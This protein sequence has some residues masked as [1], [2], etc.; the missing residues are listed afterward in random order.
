MMPL[1]SFCIHEVNP[2]TSLA[3]EKLFIPEEQGSW[4]FSI[5]Y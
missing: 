1:P 5:H 3:P 2:V 4:P